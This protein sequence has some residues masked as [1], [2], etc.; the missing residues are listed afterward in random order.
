MSIQSIQSIQKNPGGNTK[1]P[2]SKQQLYLWLITLPAENIDAMELSQNLKNFC[3]KF[4]FQ[5]EKGEETGYVHWQIYISLKQKEVFNTVKNL[6]PSAAHIEP[7]RDGW[8][9]ANYCK[10][11]DTR[12]EGPYDETSTFIKTITNLYDWQQHL[13]DMCLKEP[14][15]RT[16]VWVWESQGNRGKTQFCK[17][18]YIKH[19]ATV[20]GN[21][22]FKDIAQA[23]PANPKIVVFNITRD[24]E[25]RFNYSAV[26][27]VKDGMIFSGKYESTMKVFNS[28]HV[29]I[30]ANFQP[31]LDAMSLDRWHIINLD[32]ELRPQLR[33]RSA[34]GSVPRN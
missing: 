4:V 5:K 2:G 25:E 22:A 20:L 13:L 11:S 3:K 10:K 29:M 27:A 9:A 31:R 6:F 14:D 21:G 33:N 16:I 15:D 23:I 17:Y 12:I 24:L 32:E 28:P 18:L 26:E 19:G 30:F 34:P 7:V 8:K 1:T